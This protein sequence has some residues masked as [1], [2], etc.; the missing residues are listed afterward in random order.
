MLG[1]GQD[2]EVVTVFIKLNIEIYVSKLDL[3]Q[4]T[5]MPPEGALLRSIKSQQKATR[6][7]QKKVKLALLGKRDY[8]PKLP[9]A[10]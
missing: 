4:P 8:G 5:C 6:I 9:I 3:S 1:M 7:D 2:I 10:C